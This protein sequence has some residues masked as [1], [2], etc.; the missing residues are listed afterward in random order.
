[1]CVFWP[2][3]KGL[4]YKSQSFHSICQLIA[5]MWTRW[6]FLQTEHWSA[7]ALFCFKWTYRISTRKRR[8]I[9][10]NNFNFIV[11]NISSGYKN[12]F[13]YL[14]AMLHNSVR[15]LLANILIFFKYNCNKKLLCQFLSVFLLLKYS[16]YSS[17]WLAKDFKKF[18]LNN[19]QLVVAGVIVDT[20]IWFALLFV[21]DLWLPLSVSA[22]ATNDD[23]PLLLL[24][25][26]W[27]YIKA[28][29][30]CMCLCFCFLYVMVSTWLLDSQ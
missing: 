30:L 13:F 21:V 22:A 23:D 7:W 26:C 9:M 25:C 18:L 19:L 27:W 2:L 4:H 8:T 5:R 15:S 14:D 1:M 11:S 29:C 3:C 24:S 20:G 16:W 17:K 6:H 12:A 10:E 28:I